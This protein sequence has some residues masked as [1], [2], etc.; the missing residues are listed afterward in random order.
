MRSAW[1]QGQGP[2][3]QRLARPWLS[4]FRSQD[5]LACSRQHRLFSLTK[6]RAEYFELHGFWAAGLRKGKV[7]APLEVENLEA[8][9]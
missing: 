4:E 1:L 7:G 9:G 6:V 5:A 3:P 8:L 2:N